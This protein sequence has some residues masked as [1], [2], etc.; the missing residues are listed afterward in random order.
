MTALENGRH[1][2]I[3]DLKRSYPLL[4]VAER[5]GLRLRRSGSRRRQGSCPFHDDRN[6]SFFVD[7]EH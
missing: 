1:W 6:P 4:E 5:A 7:V 3:V 2:E